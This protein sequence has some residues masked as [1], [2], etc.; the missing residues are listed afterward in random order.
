AR[1]VG[2]GLEV[3]D[4][5]Q[6]GHKLR[7]YLGDAPLLVLPGLERIFLSS[8]RT[9]SYESFS[10]SPHSTAL[11]A[12]NR[13][14]QRLHSPG[15]LRQAAAIKCASPFAFSLGRWPGRGRSVSAPRLSST[16]RRRVR[17]TVG[18]LV[19]TSSAI[20]SSLSPSSALS[21]MRARGSLRA[22]VFP[23]RVS[24]SRGSRSAAVS[25]TST[26]PHQL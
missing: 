19:P 20:A 24:Y 3:Q 18:T 12:S 13:S 8:P 2:L 1:I 14:V 11:S 16:K 23:L 26:S 10:P 25:S 6:T 7:A 22:A 5:F 17:S 9:V 15:A 21:K 4:V